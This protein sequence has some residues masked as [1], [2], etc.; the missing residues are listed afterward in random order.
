LIINPGN[1]N[2][3]RDEPGRKPNRVARKSSQRETSN[4]YSPGMILHE[5]KAECLASIR[6]YQK[7]KSSASIF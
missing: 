5:W 3:A 4:Q 6:A 7:I 1:Q 2:V